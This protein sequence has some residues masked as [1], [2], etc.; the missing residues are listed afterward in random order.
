MSLLSF[1]PIIGPALDAASGLTSALMA[2]HQAQNA[3]QTRVD[4]LRK[5]GLNPAL[6]YDQGGA[7]VAQTALPPVGESVT[8]AVSTAADTKA[9]QADAWLKQEQGAMIEAQRHQLNISS[10]DMLLGLKAKNQLLE[11]GTGL[12]IANTGLAQQKTTQTQQGVAMTD[13]VWDTLIKQFEADL[14]STRAS[15]DATSARAALDKLARPGAEKEA[16]AMRGWLGTAR[17][18]ISTAS[19]VA[20]ALSRF[21]PRFNIWGDRLRPQKETSDDDVSNMLGRP[22]QSKRN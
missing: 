15:T 8:R 12:N 6:A 10:A 16:A 5:A 1:L 3:V 7:Q 2:R 4:D 14:L 11:T 22:Y 13:A 21:I 9:R 17:P 18:Y 20:G 19:D